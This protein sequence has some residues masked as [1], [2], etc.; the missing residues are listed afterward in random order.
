MDAR[1]PLRILLL[2]DNTLVR[3]LYE[4]RARARR[5]L[6]LETVSTPKALWE[7]I[8]S[9]S[10]RYDLVVCDGHLGAQA[11]RDTIGDLVENLLIRGIDVVVIEDAGARAS[12]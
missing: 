11:A 10:V 2:D 8:E 9:A 7:R 4:Q 12:F 1:T 5:G 6:L 3:S